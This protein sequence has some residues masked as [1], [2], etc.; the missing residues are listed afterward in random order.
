[1]LPTS[2]PAC[3]LLACMALYAGAAFARCSTIAAWVLQLSQPHIVEL[4]CRETKLI[5]SVNSALPK[6]PLL[7]LSRLLFPM[8]HQ[9]QRFLHHFN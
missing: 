3:L 2:Q 7:S 6:S 5:F 8:K 4:I 1:M 9:R